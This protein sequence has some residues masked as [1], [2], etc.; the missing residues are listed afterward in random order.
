VFLQMTS[1]AGGS[2][3]RKAQKVISLSPG[4]GRLA[5]RC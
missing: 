5:V 2:L 1:N 4:W 3:I